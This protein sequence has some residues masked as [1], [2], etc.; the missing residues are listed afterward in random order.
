M[1]TRCLVAK[2]YI[3]FYLSILKY[4]LNVFNVYGMEMNRGARG[5][6]HRRFGRLLMQRIV[7][8]WRCKVLS[9]H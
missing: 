3:P 1:F 5:V 2:V 9:K 8:I 6:K 4:F 7:N